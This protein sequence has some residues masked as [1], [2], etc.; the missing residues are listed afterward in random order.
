M[1]IAADTNILV[2]SMVQDDVEQA[3]Q[4]ARVLRSAEIIAISLACLCEIV[5]V[6]RRVYKFQRE[7]IATALEGLLNASNVVANREAASF[8]IQ[9]LRAGGDFADGVIAWEGQW[10]GGELFLSFDKKAVAALK[11]QGAAA[12]LLE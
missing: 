10:L 5:W 6:L 3:K 2:R 12:R 8:G 9:V 4:S 7:D 11:Q 1:K